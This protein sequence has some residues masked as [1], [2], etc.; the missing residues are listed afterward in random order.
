MAERNE[1]VTSSEH[2]R[3]PPNLPKK[4]INDKQNYGQ[5][6]EK[7]EL[8]PVNSAE[9]G[10]PYPRLGTVRGKPCQ[11]G[12]YWESNFNFGGGLLAGNEIC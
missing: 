1:L 9:F 5:S 7:T 3:V 10:S 4:A 12:G 11:R 6:E 8:V 2:A